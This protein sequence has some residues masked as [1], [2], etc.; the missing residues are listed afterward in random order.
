MTFELTVDEWQ[1]VLVAS[2]YRVLKARANAKRRK[3]QS[4]HDVVTLDCLDRVHAGLAAHA[5]WLHRIEQL[6]QRVAGELF[7][8]GLAC[9]QHA[10]KHTQRIE[11]A[12]SS[13]ATCCFTGAPA[14]R[15]VTLLDVECGEQMWWVADTTWVQWLEAATVVGRAP[16]WLDAALEAHLPAERVQLTPAHLDALVQEAALVRLRE[17]CVQASE[18]LSKH[19][20]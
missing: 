4:P 14:T 10:Y 7:G 8:D 3:E 16:V 11:T 18:F 15:R 19:I 5:A 12:A 6:G 9:F 2:A 17:C 13:E 1:G 20:E